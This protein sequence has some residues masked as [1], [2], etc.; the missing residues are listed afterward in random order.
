M[1][2]AEIMQCEDQDAD[3]VWSSVVCK[4]L[5]VGQGLCSPGGPSGGVGNS[6]GQWEH[7]LVEL[8]FGFLDS[9]G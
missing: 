5:L 9:N 8:L 4:T 3:C 1:L 7:G 2:A 6:V